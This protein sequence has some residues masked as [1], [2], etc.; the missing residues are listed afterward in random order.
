MTGHLH[1]DNMDVTLTGNCEWHGKEVHLA[2]RATTAQGGSWQGSADLTAVSAGKLSGR[3]L[4]KR[5]DD[6]PL[7]L[8]KD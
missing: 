4:S 2:Y 8:I 6:I 1:V 7:L 5:G 3:F